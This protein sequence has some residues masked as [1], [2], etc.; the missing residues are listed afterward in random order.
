MSFSEL[1]D[2]FNRNATVA[3]LVLSLT[4]LAWLV[5][6]SRRR[7]E[8]WTERLEAAHAAHLQSVEQIAPLASKL[9]TCVEVLERIVDRKV[10]GHQP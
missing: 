1:F 3:L 4:A 5:R 2:A 6:D 10:G 7:E 8:I 9:V